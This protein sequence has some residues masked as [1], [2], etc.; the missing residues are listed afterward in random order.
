VLSQKVSGQQDCPF[1]IKMEISEWSWGQGLSQHQQSAQDFTDPPEQPVRGKEDYPQFKGSKGTSDL[2]RSHS[3][4]GPESG[5]LIPTGPSSHPF[6]L[7]TMCPGVNSLSPF[8]SMRLAGGPLDSSPVPYL[9]HP[10]PYHLAQKQPSA[11]WLART[12]RTSP[13][14]AL[15]S[16]SPARQ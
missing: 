16:L 12:P 11:L 2:S 14:P 7:P 9:F 10:C 3:K 13:C 8:G 5:F 6:C 1:L 4:S 15:A